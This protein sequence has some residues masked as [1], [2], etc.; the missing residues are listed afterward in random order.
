SS[1]LR[2]ALAAPRRATARADA[3]RPSTADDPHAAAA[4]KLTASVGISSPPDPALPTRSPAAAAISAAAAVSRPSARARSSARASAGMSVTP[5]YVTLLSA[6]ITSTTENAEGSATTRTPKSQ[7]SIMASE[8]GLLV[9]LSERALLHF[10]VE[11][12]AVPDERLH[13]HGHVAA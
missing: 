8:R 12:L 13:H 5:R 7:I 3:S 11:R 2:A 1:F 9:L 6:T 10:H 4:A